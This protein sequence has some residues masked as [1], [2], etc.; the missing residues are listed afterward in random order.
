M[1]ATLKCVFVLCV[2]LLAAS[3]SETD[4]INDPE[5]DADI[6]FA[7]LEDDEQIDQSVLGFW[8]I[9]YSPGLDSPGLF[10]FNEGDWINNGTLNMELLIV[11]FL[12]GN[13][14]QASLLYHMVNDN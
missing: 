10:F 6:L 13:K 7:Q 9:D 8:S 12:E 1:L 3:C 5:A 2:V 11:E 4:S 14:W